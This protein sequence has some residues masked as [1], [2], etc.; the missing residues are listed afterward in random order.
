MHRNHSL[1]QPSKTPRKLATGQWN[2]SVPNWSDFQQHF[3]C[4]LDR[5]C[6]GGEDE[7]D[8]PYTGHCGQHRLTVDGRCYQLFRNYFT[9]WNNASYICVRFVIFFR[10]DRFLVHVSNIWIYVISFVCRQRAKSFKLE[11]YAPA[12]LPF[13]FIFILFIYLFIFFL[14]ICYILSGTM[15]IFLFI[16]LSVTLSLAGPIRPAQTKN[17]LTSFS[18]ISHS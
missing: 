9:S 16:P 18:I 2:C 4:N 11:F 17:L 1:M 13:I 12:L 8:C 3:M 10:D 6:A 5:E 15:K 7:L 14:H